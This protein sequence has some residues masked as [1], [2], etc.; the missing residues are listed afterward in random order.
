MI[1]VNVK[2]EG[3]TPLLV[4]RFHE[5]AAAEATSGS[6]SRKER[7]GPE[8]DAR[9]RLYINGDVPF[10]PAEN[11]RQSMIG[12]ASR[13]KIGRRA[14]TTDIAASIYILPFELPLMGE[15]HVD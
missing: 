9:Q 6:H 11:I 12:A 14:A 2:I 3:L 1:T 10:F 15:W 7:L 5:E 4:N 8:E 13:H